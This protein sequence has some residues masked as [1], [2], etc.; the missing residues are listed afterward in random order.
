MI[1]W[2]GGGRREIL[3]VFQGKS[4][5]SVFLHRLLFNYFD[6]GVNR[7]FGGIF[8]ISN[9]MLSVFVIAFDWAHLQGW[10]IIG[11]EKTDWAILSQGKVIF[12]INFRRAFAVILPCMKPVVI[13]SVFSFNIIF[14]L[15]QYYIKTS[16]R[17][18]HTSFF[19]SK[20]AWW[21]SF[22][23]KNRR[24]LWHYRPTII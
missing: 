10:F 7:A 24:L 12:R 17:P 18:S 5:L 4:V 21:M 20:L 14:F 19:V 13:F 23:A 3:S 6:G 1:V 11:S 2:L 9:G 16:R 8:V 22:F 15:I